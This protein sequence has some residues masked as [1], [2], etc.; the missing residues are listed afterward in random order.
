MRHKQGDLFSDY[1]KRQVRRGRS[2]HG[3]GASQNRGA[4]VQIIATVSCLW[5]VLVVGRL[6]QLQISEHQ[7]WQGSALRQHASQFKLASERGRIFDRNGR[8]LATSVPGGSVYV[9]PHQVRDKEYAAQRLAAHL[10][11]SEEVVREKLSSESRFI[12][13]E[14]Q[15]PRPIADAIADEE[16]AGVGYYLESRRYYPYGSAASTLL[17]KVGT[18]GTGLSGLEAQFEEHLGSLELKTAARRDGSGK[19]LHV[20]QEV[21]S[22]PKGQS[23]SLT[24]DASIQLIMDEEL[25]VGQERAQAERAF[26]VMMNGDTGE[27]LG[28]SQSPS[29][30][31]NH[32]KLLSRE[33]LKNH[34]LELSF[35]PGSIL[36]PFVAALALE[37]GVTHFH[38]LIDCEKG[39]F[40]YGGHTIN[41]VH[42]S[43]LLSTY[44]V[45]VHSSNVGM[46]KLGD[47]LGKEKIYQGLRQFGFGSRSGVGYPGEASG[48]L[49]T[50]NKWYP[51][52][53]ATHSF[54]QGVAVTP[55]Q[56]VRGVSALVNGGELPR[57]K[58]LM[59]GDS[60][61]QRER[62]LSSRV[63][64]MAKAMMI[65]VVEDKG[66]TGSRARIP[67]ITVGGKT[68]TAQRARDDGRGYEPG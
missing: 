4:R 33:L 8:I 35:E 55:L 15:V 28:L 56:I 43:A 54:G 10:A 60:Q 48:L 30:N 66:G 19:L 16:L 14:R 42:P 36:K 40:R 38:E 52:D 22:L 49:R 46:T 29:P 24:L 67:G 25:R 58:I 32:P 9:R 2:S 53:V 23:L 45:V 44:D 68:G 61:Y 57:A 37:E 18:D 1:A 6:Y 17:G 34:A 21:S 11:I 13:V 12:W 39:A 7:V 31:F 51:I 47:R 62:V 50:P 26:A 41:D 64:E 3:K 63:A 27:V 59:D 20:S 65:G 5:A